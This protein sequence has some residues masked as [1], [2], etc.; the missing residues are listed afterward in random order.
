MAGKHITAARPIW[1]CAFLMPDTKLYLFELR[2][3]LGLPREQDPWDSLRVSPS[4]KQVGAM[5]SPSSLTSCAKYVLWALSPYSS[6]C[7]LYPSG[8]QSLQTIT[9]IPFPSGFQTGS[10]RSWYSQQ[11]RKQ[12]EARSLS[13]SHDSSANSGGRDARTAPTSR[14]PAASWHQLHLYRCRWLRSLVSTVSLCFQLH[15]QEI[16]PMGFLPEQQQ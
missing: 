16:S 5:G 14:F 6:F 11:V 1:N 2:D 13:A 3:D 4:P 10:A 15:E 9:Q 8:S 7:F 12:R